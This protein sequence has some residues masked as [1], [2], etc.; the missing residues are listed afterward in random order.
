MRRPRRGSVGAESGPQRVD[1]RRVPQ[2]P[3]AGGG[4]RRS[5]YAST[6]QAAL[7][8][9]RTPSRDKLLEVLDPPDDLAERLAELLEA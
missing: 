3:P 8:A 4:R 2:A 9:R 5:P 7:A 1:G 6:F